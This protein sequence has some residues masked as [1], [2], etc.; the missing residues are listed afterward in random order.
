VSKKN[1]YIL[2]GA[3][4]VLL[5]LYAFSGSD[6]EESTEISVEVERGLFE[7]K[8]FTTGELEAKNSVDIKGPKGLRSAGIWRVQ[9]TDLIPEGTKVKKGDY[10]ARLDKSE[11]SDKIISAG[12]NL[13]KS[14]SQYVQTR[15]DTTLDLRQVR[16]EI[17]NLDYDLKDKTIIL[18][19]SKYEPPATIR[20][21]EI[22]LEKAERAYKEKVVSYQIKIKQSRA[23]MQEA[24]ASLAKDQNKYD[25]L[26]RLQ[27]GFTIMAPEDGMVI[28]QREWSGKKKGVGSEV[29]AWDPT[30]ATLPDLTSM[31]SQTYVNEVDIRKVEVGQ[32]VQIS[33]D[34]FPDKNLTGV[35]VEVANMGEQLPGTDS[36]VFEVRIEVDEVDSVIRPGMTTGNNIIASS[37]EDVLFTPLESIHSQEDSLLFVYVKSGW[38]ITKQEVQIGERN[39]NYAIV[40]SGL[41]EGDEVMLSTP[42]DGE[43]MTLEPL[44]ADL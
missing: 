23:K 24:A 5:L 37:T 19:Q 26:R 29:G 35:V 1:K 21:A 17:I 11:L 28:Y 16:L 30:V 39:D 20:Q 42:E 12:S 41:E 15:M 6:P 27:D 14:E 32:I 13:S 2:T 44:A 36:K 22:A 18:E 4:L 31:I 33:L 40:L 7:V 38:G 3:G 43:D 10:I 25:M 8:V 34:A 9:I